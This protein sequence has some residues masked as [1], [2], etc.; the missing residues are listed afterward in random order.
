MRQANLPCRL[1]THSILL[2]HSVITLRLPTLREE[3]LITKFGYVNVKGCVGSSASRSL[4]N[5]PK[6]KKRRESVNPILDKLH[7]ASMRYQ[8]LRSSSYMSPHM[9]FMTWQSTSN[10]E[11]GSNGFLYLEGYSPKTNTF[12]ICLHKIFFT[13][14]RRL[15]MGSTTMGKDTSILMMLLEC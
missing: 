2:S 11:S 4:V 3:R 13:T 7:H 6:N 9:P 15:H 10:D 5:A 12:Q 1:N 8:K 14:E